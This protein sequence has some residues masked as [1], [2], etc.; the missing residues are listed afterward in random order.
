MEQTKEL[1]IDEFFNLLRI[2]EDTLY[3]RVSCL[4]F[5]HKGTRFFINEEEMF[6]KAAAKSC[7]YSHD[8]TSLIPTTVYKIVDDRL[9]YIYED[10]NK[11]LL[12]S[13]QSYKLH[14]KI[15]RLLP[16]FID[17][18]HDTIMTIATN[19]AG[20]TYSFMLELPLYTY[21]K[22]Y[23]YRGETLTGQL[24]S[25]YTP[26]NITHST[27]NKTL[28]NFALESASIL[29]ADLHIDYMYGT[30]TT[31]P[32]GTLTS[33]SDIDENYLLSGTSTIFDLKDVNYI[34]TFEFHSAS[35][36]AIH[37]EGTNRSSLHKKIFTNIV[38]IGNLVQLINAL[39]GSRDFY[40]YSD[41]IMDIRKYPK[42]KVMN[43][44]SN[45]NPS[46]GGFVLDR[47]QYNTQEHL[48]D[49]ANCLPRRMN[50]TFYFT[51]SIDNPIEEALY[52]NT[53]YA[54]TSEVNQVYTRQIVVTKYE[55]GLTA[56]NQTQEKKLVQKNLLITDDNQA[57]RSLY[58]ELL[59]LISD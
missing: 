35:S 16:L 32:K 23:P 12:N 5:Q 6:T 9:D 26:H 53:V 58:R 28:Y 42:E 45:I 25:Q 47:S 4:R 11:K 7:N 24:I 17:E 54:V 27:T 8:I 38:S 13:T 14:K 31:S 49:I 50:I 44:L 41:F 19:V 57:D 51:D 18:E 15:D 21:F 30:L 22:I 52:N 43:V 46:I 29:G 40:Y 33:L 56:P 1:N 36:L 34:T 59:K 2:T 55:E 10:K 39:E 3:E 48:Y 20:V 37:I